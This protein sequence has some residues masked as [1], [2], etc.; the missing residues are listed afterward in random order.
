MVYGSASGDETCNYHTVIKECCQASG[1]RVNL[2]KLEIFFN[3]N[4]IDSMRSSI[5]GIFGVKEASFLSK[6]LGTPS[7]GQI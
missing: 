7:K 3:R 5:M 2:S 1:Q 4:T 6:Y